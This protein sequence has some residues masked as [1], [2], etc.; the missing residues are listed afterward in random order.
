MSAASVGFRLPVVI[1]ALLSACIMASGGLVA[2]ATASVPTILPFDGNTGWINSDPLTPQSLRG[3][4]VLVDFW[5][6]TCINCLKELPYVRT[7]YDR[8]K[9]YGF[10]VIGVHTPE[11]AFSGEQANVA[12]AVK[13]LDITWPV[14]LDGQAAIWQRYHNAFWP[15]EFLA[16]ADGRVVLDHVGE[17]DYPAT[18]AKIQSLI[19]AQHPSAQLPKPMAL[20]AVDSYT[21]AG[22]VCYPQ[23]PEV[24]VGLWRSPDAALGNREGYHRGDVVN[25]HD[26]GHNHFD[27]FVYL[28]GPWF[29]A[30]QAM[31]HART[32]AAASDHIDLR[33]HA[34]EVVSVLKPEAGKPITVYVEQDGK[35]LAQQDAGS[36]VRYDADGRAFVTVDAP[37]AYEL[38]MNRHFGHHDLTLR[39]VEYGL[40]V[41]TFDFE[42]C[43]VGADK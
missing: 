8:Y 40:G 36:D 7:W 39:P 17:G 23:T 28:Q 27:G 31:V 29:N 20:L 42:S 41:Y 4:I 19:K 34:L 21:K 22:A 13:R 43:E 30:E 6:Y 9:Q 14:V 10:V 32:D 18:E 12:A 38:V 1:V 11:F 35:P 26:S 16:D 33:Y 15:H 3:K 5:E 25:Y 2:A 24:Y 37:R